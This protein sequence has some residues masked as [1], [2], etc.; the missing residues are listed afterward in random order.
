MPY[1]AR[2]EDAATVFTDDV[3]RTP[4]GWRF[5]EVEIMLAWLRRD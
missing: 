1:K 3:A 2:H 5:S 4:E